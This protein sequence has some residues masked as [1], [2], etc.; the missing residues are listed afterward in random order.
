MSA[1]VRRDERIISAG[2]GGQ[3]VMS[4]GRLIAYAGMIEGRE[5]AW[6]P[7]YGPEMRGGTANCHVTVSDRAI[8]TPIIAGDATIVVAMNLPSLTKFESEL[9]EGGVLLVNSSLVDSGAHR[10]DVREVRVP[11]NAIAADLG[12]PRAANMVMLGALL[13]SVPFLAEQSIIEAMYKVFGD[14]KAEFI[15]A[16]RKAMEAGMGVVAPR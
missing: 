4:L 5:V 2:F 12:T 13:A 10:S 14:A 9:A 15:P 11:A 7:S 8:G 1:N 3:G 16:N 6:L